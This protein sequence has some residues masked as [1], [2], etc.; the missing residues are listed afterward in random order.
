VQE[1]GDIGSDVGDEERGRGVRFQRKG[2]SLAAL[3]DRDVLDLLATPLADVLS[4]VVVDVPEIDLVRLSIDGAGVHRVFVR[5][6]K[7]LW[8]PPE[9]SVEAKEL[10]SVLDGITILRASANLA[11]TGLAPLEDPID[12]EFVSST[13]EKTKFRIGLGPASAPEGERVQVERDGRR[14]VAKDQ[15]LH[16]RLLAVLK[17]G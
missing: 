3:L 11:G 15:G 10:H 14:A 17:P 1:G 6:A 5:N 8:T 16:A 2:D 12:L 4:L 13:R 7:G 9:I